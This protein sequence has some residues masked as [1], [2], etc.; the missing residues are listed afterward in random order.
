MKYYHYI[1][2]KNKKNSTDV[3]DGYGFQTEVVGDDSKLEA[4]KNDKQHCK[5]TGLF[6]FIFS[7]LTKPDFFC[8]FITFLQYKA[9][10]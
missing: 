4:V 9:C 10:Q 3:K 1:F 2:F 7:K 6:I 5:E 8:I